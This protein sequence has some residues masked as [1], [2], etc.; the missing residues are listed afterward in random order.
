MMFITAGTLTIGRPIG[1]KQ[2]ELIVFGEKVRLD[3]FPPTEFHKVA[4]TV[5]KSILYQL[6]FHYSII[7]L[8]CTSPR[9]HSYGLDCIYAMFLDYV[10]RH[11]RHYHIVFDQR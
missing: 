3:V 4:L 2:F 9:Q 5:P 8:V 6:A 1:G 10:V 11:G 7:T